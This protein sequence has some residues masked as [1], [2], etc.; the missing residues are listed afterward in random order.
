[1][2]R[3][4]VFC[5][6]LLLVCRVSA[7][8]FSIQH[9]EPANWWV[10]MKYH[11]VELLVY[12]ENIGSTT[13]SIDYPGVRLIETKKVKSANYLF[14]T[15][16]IA[17]DAKPGKFPIRFMRDNQLKS[18]FT[19]QLLAREPGSASRKGFLPSDA[20]YLIN[21]DRFAN[22]KSS[23]D[24][25]PGMLELP[26]RKFSGGRHGGDIAGMSAHLDYIAAMGFTQ[27]WPTP[28][29]ENNQP[30]Y[31]YHGYAATNLY[32][33]DSRYGSNADFKQFVGD[34]RKRGL[35]VIQDIVLNHIGSSHWWM[36]DLPTKDW[37]NFPDHYT[38][39]SHRRTT[40]QD[41]H[42]APE[43]REIFVG[44]WFVKTMPDLN[45]RNPLLARYLI[46]N[47]IW[48][49][50]YAGLSGIRE[51]TYGYSDEKFLSQWGKALLDEYP[52]FS[53]V[54]EEWSNN[55]AIVAHWQ[56]GK[57]NPDGHV[58]YMPSMM[59][60]PIHEALRTA[61]SEPE[62]WGTGTVRLYEALANDFVY[63]DAGN[64]VIFAENHDTSR[65][66]SLLDED[67]DLFKM[68]MVYMASMRGI[69]QFY[70]GSEILMTSPKERDDGA[71]RADMPGGWNGDAKNAFTGKGLTAKERDMQ[72]FMKKLLNW[73][74]SSEVIHSGKLQHFA[75]TD[76]IYVYFRYLEKRAVMVVLNKNAEPKT[77]ELKRF[78]QFLSD[79][80]AGVDV[81]SG[82]S[83]SLGE[84]LSLPAKSAQ[85]IEL[86]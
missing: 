53:M 38:E 15:I 70:Y 24:K 74:K 5:V 34:A 60:F 76:G 58:P 3:L 41:P 2:K 78:H 35:G 22:G 16:D 73:R 45:Q 59:D 42:A 79:K 40:I 29:T 82:K 62:A 20:I 75:P 23:N 48:W 77:L 26:D 80:K 67:V 71:V 57:I 63:P 52:D 1:M 27:I 68:A 56:R 18:S 51:D 25:A 44:G 85:L 19:Y 46:Q 64:L 9:L 28:L 55:P 83:V 8:E 69:P 21:P 4:W 11:Q 32:K 47:S 36:A 54:G 84:S 12:G 43:D 13:P 37:V 33:I 86:N 7:A 6:G 14:V 50:E 81:M 10:G 39:T 30:K 61:L 66:Y 49:V 65:I 31:S 72:D 17:E